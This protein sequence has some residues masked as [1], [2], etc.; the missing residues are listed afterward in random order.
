MQS[1]RSF[2]FKLLACEAGQ[3]LVGGGRAHARRF[4]ELKA[5]TS[6]SEK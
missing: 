2:T 3:D 4:A 1:G 5:V 6:A